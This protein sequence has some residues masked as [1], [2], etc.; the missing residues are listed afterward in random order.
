MLLVRIKKC[1]FVGKSPANAKPRAQHKAQAGIFQSSIE[2]RCLH[3]F[4]KEEFTHTSLQYEER[5]I[6]PRHLP[7]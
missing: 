6:A 2:M 1:L 7:D 3:L 4:L 5:W